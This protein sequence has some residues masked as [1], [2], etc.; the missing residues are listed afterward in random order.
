MHPLIRQREFI[1]ENIDFL[2]EFELEKVFKKIYVKVFRNKTNFYLNEHGKL[3][4][5]EILVKK[6]DYS[7]RESWGVNFD[8]T[9]DENI[10]L[11]R[12]QLTEYGITWIEF[13]DYEEVRFL[14]SSYYFRRT[15][16]SFSM[17]ANGV[18]SLV[19]FLRYLVNGKPDDNLKEANEFLEE[20]K[21]SYNQGNYEYAIGN[22]KVKSFINGRLDIKGL[23]EEQE[24]IIDRFAEIYKKLTG[25]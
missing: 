23:T 6:K 22:L 14:W 18:S 2:D 16:K 11:L 10:Q 9:I 3:E 19:Y 4:G 7:S 12:N 25:R 24:R 8:K 17:A 20:R 5:I 13:K 21:I 1:S 15:E